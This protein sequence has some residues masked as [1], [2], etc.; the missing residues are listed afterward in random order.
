MYKRQVLVQPAI[1]PIGESM[2]MAFGFA[3]IIG[4]FITLVARLR[5]GGDDDDPWDPDDGAVV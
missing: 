3:G 5:P 2:A 1:L 4:G